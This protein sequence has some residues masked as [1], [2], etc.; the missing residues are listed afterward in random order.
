MVV[1]ARGRDQSDLFK[2]ERK[3]GAGNNRGLFLRLMKV[4]LALLVLSQSKV[5][6]SNS[7]PL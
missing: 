7:F 2:M 4:E 6:Y 5:Q 3:S 1:V